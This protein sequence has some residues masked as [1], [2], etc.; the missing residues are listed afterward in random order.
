MQILLKNRCIKETSTSSL[1]FLIENYGK[2]MF[3]ESKI[4]LCY[5]PNSE[6]C[7]KSGLAVVMS[8]NGIKVDKDEEANILFV[9]SAKN[10]MEHLKIISELMDLAENKN[11]LKNIIKAENNSEIDEIIRKTTL[12]A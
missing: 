9:L 1:K 7:I 5:D 11:L 3:I 12:T 2:Y 8:K 10:K 6:N 4:L